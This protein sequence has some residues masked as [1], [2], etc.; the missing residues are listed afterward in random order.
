MVVAVRSLSGKSE[1]EG[2][3]RPGRV[4]LI[5]FLSFGRAKGGEG[6]GEKGGS[7]VSIAL[8]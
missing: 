3:V 5:L 7:G 8:I 2:R 1:D 4:S 6:K